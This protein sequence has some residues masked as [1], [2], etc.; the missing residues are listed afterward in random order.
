[1]KDA[2]SLPEEKIYTSPLVRAHRCLFLTENS[3][4]MRKNLGIL[5]NMKRYLG[6]LFPHIWMSAQKTYNSTA[7]VEEYASLNDLQKPEQTILGLVTELVKNGSM[8]DI[9]VG[10]GRTT[11]Y[12]AP[13]AR[14]YIGIDYAENMIEACRK[15]FHPLASNISFLHCDARDMSIF[16]DGQF[17]FVLAS[18]NCLDGLSHADRIKILGEMKRVC[19]ST[20]RVCFSSHNLQC[21]DNYFDIFKAW[22]KW[23]N[24]KWRNPIKLLF[25]IYRYAWLLALNDSRKPLAKR[26]YVI[27]ND[28]THNFGISLYYIRP[29]K[30]MEQLE[31]LGFAKTRVFSLEGNEI[32]RESE[33]AAARDWYLYYLC[34]TG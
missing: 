6:K 17:D 25:T 8:L 12:F 14:Q 31:E 2:L 22:L 33:V 27:I 7:I 10:G 23:K 30:Q 29:W 20:G 5:Q 15:K 26:D 1:M 11:R 18:Y 13:L 4:C 34:T 9:G 21:I 32:A 24:V 16:A 19:K 28:G 3:H